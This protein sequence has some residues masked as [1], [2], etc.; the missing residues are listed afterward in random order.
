[1]FVHLSFLLETHT[2]KKNFHFSLGGSTKTTQTSSGST[3]DKGRYNL[4]KTSGELNQ[5]LTQ[6]GTCGGGSSWIGTKGLENTLKY[7]KTE[8]KTALLEIAIILL[9]VLEV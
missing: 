3:S 5:S 9:Q 8:R 1:M 6:S 2:V 4:G 7:S